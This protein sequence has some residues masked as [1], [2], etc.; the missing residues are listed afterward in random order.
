MLTNRYVSVI[1]I[2]VMSY[3]VKCY[4]SFQAYDKW[5]HK[6]EENAKISL[7]NL[8][9]QKMD[10]SESNELVN[11]LKNKN[12]QLQ[13]LVTHYKTIIDDTVCTVASIVCNW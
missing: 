8:S 7:N 12:S 3:M 1:D 4:L 5:L 13:A 11:D 2:T 9:S 6:F 10:D